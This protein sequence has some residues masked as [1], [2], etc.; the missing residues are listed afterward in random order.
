M[1]EPAKIDDLLNRYRSLE[2]LGVQ[3]GQHDVFARPGEPIANTNGL[4]KR[5]IPWWVH[6]VFAM[7]FAGVLAAGPFLVGLPLQT[8]TIL[9]AIIFPAMV[10]AYTIAM[11]S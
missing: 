5:G 1:G 3:L 2:G 8:A 6:A 4:G 10:V 9:A 7:T 11:G